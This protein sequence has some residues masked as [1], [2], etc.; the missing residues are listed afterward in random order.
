MQIVIVF[1]SEGNYSA[2]RTVTAAKPYGD[3]VTITK[4]DC[5]G[6]VQKRMGTELRR[7]WTEHKGVQIRLPSGEYVRKGLKG[8]NRLTADLVNKLQ[9]YYGIAIRSHIGD[10]PGMITAITAIFCHHANDH[11]YCPPGESSWCKYN[12]GDPSYAPKE[13]WPEVLELM[14]PVFE[15]LSDEDLLERVQRGDTQNSNE[16]LHSLIWRRCPKEIF[17]SHEII[18]FSTSLAII[19]RNAGNVGLVK[20]LQS[21]GVGDTAFSQRLLEK[22]DVRKEYNI[23]RSRS[24]ESKKR[25]Q[26][27]RGMKKRVEDVL[28]REGNT[29]EAGGF[30][31]EEEGAESGSSKGARK[32]KRKKTVREQESQSTR[33]RA[34]RAT[35]SVS[36]APSEDCPP[37]ASRRRQPTVRRPRRLRDGDDS[38]WS[39][40]GQ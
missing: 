8:K 17:A 20:V 31:M 11:S 19:Q 22:I 27:L 21:L 30:G 23:L 7:L 5:I 35:S 9:N 3:D 6:H 4:S 25:R 38:D 14:E 29:Y 40:S 2:F 15:R 34:H 26:V 1:I 10:K 37:P 33:K 39:P 18:K 36:T 12:R 16:S 32:R 13:I 28:E 24:L